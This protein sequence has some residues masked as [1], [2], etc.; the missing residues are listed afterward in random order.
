MATDT[1][2]PAVFEAIK[3]FGVQLTDQALL[4]KCLRGA[5]QNNNEGWNGM[6]WGICPIRHSLL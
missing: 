2:P 5:T 6:L 1:I 3:P 4:E